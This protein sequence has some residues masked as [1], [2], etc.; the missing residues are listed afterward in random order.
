M[1]SQTK[2]NKT[3]QNKTKQNKT[4]QDSTE[5]TTEKP[6]LLRQERFYPG[7]SRGRSTDSECGLSNEQAHRQTHTHTHTHTHVTQLSKH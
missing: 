2:Q 4:S 6:G 1:L 7:G 3:K 5:G